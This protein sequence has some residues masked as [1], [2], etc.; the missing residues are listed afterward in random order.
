M[1]GGVL[2]T[3]NA[4]WFSDL[5]RRSVGPGVRCF[6][7]P[8]LCDSNGRSFGGIPCGRVSEMVWGW[9]SLCCGAGTCRSG[10]IGV[11]ARTTTWFVALRAGLAHQQIYF[12]SLGNILFR[13]AAAVRNLGIAT[14][15]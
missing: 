13:S 6:E 5:T 8:T 14:G 3:R 4:V 7:P 15:G 9:G 1:F 11:T 10:G 2:S 12:Q